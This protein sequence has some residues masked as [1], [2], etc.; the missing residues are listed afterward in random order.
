M[1][2]AR[3]LP[4]RHLRNFLAL[5]V[6]NYGAM[7]VSMVINAILTRRLGAERFGH[8]AL[9]LTTSQIVALLAA[10]WTQTAV[11]RFGALEFAATG[12]ISATIWTRWWMALPWAAAPLVVALA[13]SGPVA[14]YLSI[15][16]SGLLLVWLHFLATFLL[17]TA[18]AAFQARQ[19]MSRYGAVLFF[20]K[21][22][23][24]LLILLAS[25][26]VLRSALTVLVAYAVSSTL[27]AIGALATLG[28]AALMPVTFSRS[29]YQH[30]WRF[31]SPL[32]LST[33]A[34]M[35]GTSWF[36]YI[37]LR[38]YRSPAELGWYSL[39]VLL[40]GVLQQVA[41]ISSTLLLPRLSVIVASGEFEKVR[42]LI[43]RVL[44]YWL[45]ATAVLFSVAIVAGAPLVPVVFGSAFGPS[46]RV[47]AVLMLAAS[48]FALFS[49]L[50]ALITALGATW[51]LT[52]ICFLSGLVNVA[53]DFLLIP[54]Y[55][56]VGGAVATVLAYVTL[57]DR[58]PGV[59]PVA[60][61]SERI[62]AVSARSASGDDVCAVLWDRW[63]RVLRGG[64]SGAACDGPLVDPALRTVRPSGHGPDA[65]SAALGAVEHEV[66]CATNPPPK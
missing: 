59:H 53:S 63:P 29:A 43:T 45:L 60:S 31:S 46:V 24:A 15:P 17:T 54:R 52:L 38:W 55:G 39:G 62:R 26:L 64:A 22:V 13:G 49:V 57:I 28:R 1:T 6:G 23:M 61:R 27:V 33:W 3:P 16:P 36:D 40:A 65:K 5:G 10:N 25:P 7:A 9:L 42:L 66:R 34:A 32:I 8:L 37:V 44:P 19:E 56:I 47:L 12:R 41:I 51:T 30:M 18:G 4:I 21:A 58:R 20:D 2:S 11:V 48:A 35:F 14:A 50:S